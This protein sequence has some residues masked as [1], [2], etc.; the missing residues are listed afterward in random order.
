MVLPYW[1]VFG[2]WIAAA[3]TV[4]LYSFA[5]KDNVLYKFSEHLFLGVA[6]GYSFTLGLDAISRTGIAPIVTEGEL[7]YIVPIIFGLLFFGKYLGR[8][9]WIAR[10][11]SMFVLGVGLSLAVRTAPEA[12][13]LKQVAASILPLYVPG[14]PVMT[15]THILM[16]LIIIGGLLYFV[17]TFVP[18]GGERRPTASYRVYEVLTRIGIYGMMVGFGALFARTVM[19]RVAFFIGRLT[20][21]MS[22]E[23]LGATIV[24]TILAAIAIV[25]SYTQERRRSTAGS[26]QS[27]GAAQTS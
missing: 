1:D 4:W 16:V 17:F 6:A 3:I 9:A 10:Y 23:A 20:F 15:I 14:D 21:L 18:G 13:I 22:P 27:S 7:G 5:F 19:T 8:Y 25:Y 26:A 11:G 2:V 12:F 24:A